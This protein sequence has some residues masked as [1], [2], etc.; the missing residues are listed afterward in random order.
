MAWKEPVL[1]HGLWIMGKAVP[2]EQRAVIDP[3]PYAVTGQDQGGSGWIQAGAAGW[4][5]SGLGL[6]VGTAFAPGQ[7][8]GGNDYIADR[9]RIF[10]Q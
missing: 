8:I 1:P 2:D 4:G 5:P 9:R 3:E 7:I 6:P 10:H